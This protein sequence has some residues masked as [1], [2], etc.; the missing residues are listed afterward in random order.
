LTIEFTR[1]HQERTLTVEVLR[2]LVRLLVLVS[3]GLGWRVP[4]IF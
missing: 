1:T 2:C 3:T 4:R